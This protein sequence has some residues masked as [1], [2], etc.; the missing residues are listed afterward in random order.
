MRELMQGIRNAFEAR[1]AVRE[2]EHVL[3]LSDD[4][5]GS[6]WLGQLTMDVIHSMGAEAVLVAINPDD[7]V[8]E[9]P[10]PQVAA[11]MKVVGA[12]FRISDKADLVHSTARKE[13]TAAGARYYILSPAE[14]DDLKVPISSADL[15]VIKD[16]SVNLSQ[17]LAQTRVAKVTTSAGTNLTMTLTGRQSLA[18]HPLN[19]VIASLNDYAEAAIAPIEGSAEGTI[20]ADV[21]ILQWNYLFREPLR[22]KV[23]A[24]R[25]VDVSGPEHDAERLR[26]A[27]AT[28]ADASNI[29]E[30]GIGTSHIIPLVM[31]GNRRD[32]ARIGTAHIGIG[33]NDDIGG[34]TWS[35][36]HLDCLM[37]QTYVELDNVPIL[38]DGRLLI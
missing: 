15:Q 1:M 25:V 35:N 33:R 20:V 32:A 17:R 16:R 21:C 37:S 38:K 12:I 14:V 24:G 11:A 10:P 22:I 8:G 23:A 6:I 9:E 13:A 18:L 5:G 3:I 30:L 28:D 7:I 2:K 36:I 31:R 27:L 34:K 19:Q 26:K 29:A 4:D